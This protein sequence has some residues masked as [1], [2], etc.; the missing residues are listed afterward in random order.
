MTSHARTAC[1]IVDGTVQRRCILSL[2][3]VIGTKSQTDNAAAKGAPSDGKNLVRQMLGHPVVQHQPASCSYRQTALPQMPL[4]N[5]NPPTQVEGFLELGE[6]VTRIRGAELAIKT[7]TGDREAAVDVTGMINNDAEVRQVNASL[8]PLLDIQDVDPGV[9]A[10]V[11]LPTR[12]NFA[13]PNFTAKCPVCEK[14]FSTYQG[15]M[16]HVDHHRGRYAFFCSVCGRGF[17]TKD[18]LGN[19]VRG[20]TGEKLYC[21]CGAGFKTHQ[22][23]RM[24]RKREQHERSIAY[25]ER[26]LNWG[27]PTA[28]S[29][30]A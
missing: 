11:E 17:M 13:D 30:K 23:L 15:F 14:S 22:A 5:L 28:S 1:P 6:Y 19:H 3:T 20:H 16:R 10:G 24:H 12:R 25:D 21:D 18:H 27:V 29:N 26:W 4:S 7:E 9:F 8:V 2:Q